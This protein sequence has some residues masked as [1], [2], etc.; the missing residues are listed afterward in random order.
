MAT[1]LMACSSADSQTVHVGPTLGQVRQES[2]D[3]CFQ[4]GG[5]SRAEAWIDS[6]CANSGS[7][8]YAASD[9]T[10]FH[11]MSCGSGGSATSGPYFGGGA[12]FTPPANP[13]GQFPSGGGGGSSGATPAPPPPPPPDAPP[14]AKDWQCAC[15]GSDDRVPVQGTKSEAGH[16]VLQHC[17]AKSGSCDEP[18]GDFFMVARTSKALR[19]LFVLDRKE[20]T[21]LLEK[22][23]VARAET[24]KLP[25][26]ICDALRPFEGFEHPYFYFGGAVTATVPGTGLQKGL[27]VVFD[28]TNLQAAV[29]PYRKD[30][31]VTPN[32]ALGL[33]GYMG[34]GFGK[35]DNVVAAWSG[36]FVDATL[37]V[38]LLPK[39]LQPLN[40]QGGV[41]ESSDGTVKGAVIGA[42][43]SVGALPLPGDYAQGV[44]VWEAW[45]QGTAWLLEHTIN[46]AG[47]TLRF[48]V[49]QPDPNR[50]EAVY[51]YIQY[52]S[53]T[54]MIKAM[55]S[56]PGGLL[57]GP[58][59]L[60]AM[61]LAA[62]REM[63]MSISQ[64]CPD[65]DAD[66][67]DTPRP[68]GPNGDGKV[69]LFDG[70]E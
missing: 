9:P 51:A 5:H 63:G 49:A 69:L 40:V 25:F 61:A 27:D 39:T 42:G 17:A 1:A 66:A 37:S 33:G 64:L 20:L 44:G 21:R 28:L 10:G 62:Q 19:A 2:G 13:G 67:D 70:I 35:K 34:W 8:T 47:T 65:A 6:N 45:D 46:D 58:A 30:L 60:Q 52:P 43:V 14:P 26:D 54:A 36:T 11:C 32:A 41:F 31:S 48:T 59:A 22:R 56:S 38:N 18:G 29:F 12:G 23:G 4:H 7:Y 15:A 55:A 68:R 53:V 50:P 3:T 24:D 16:Y 57:T